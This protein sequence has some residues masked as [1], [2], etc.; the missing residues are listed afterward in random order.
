LRSPDYYRRK[1]I[2]AAHCAAKAHLPEVQ[3]QFE[4]LSQQ[5]QALA[6]ESEYIEA[7]YAQARRDRQRLTLPP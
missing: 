3:Q 2:Y 7:F 6:T 4:C 1:A 5:Y